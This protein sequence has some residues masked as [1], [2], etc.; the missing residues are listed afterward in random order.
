MF[1]CT[2]M[3]TLNRAG[4][5]APPGRPAE[6]TALAGRPGSATLPMSVHEESSELFGPNHGREQVNEQGQGNEADQYIF[7][8][9]L[10]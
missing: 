1:L 10:L 4:R 7:H 8:R 5:D 2:H 3:V 6:R 9:V